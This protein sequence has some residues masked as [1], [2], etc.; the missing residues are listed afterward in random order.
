MKEQEIRQLLV[1]E[2]QGKEF[3]QCGPN[4]P[5]AIMSYLKKILGISSS[6][7]S[8]KEE[9]ATARLSYIGYNHNQTIE[10]PIVTIH[11]KKQ[12][13]DSHYNWGYS[14]CDWTIKDIEVVLCD[15]NQNLDIEEVIQNAEKYVKEHLKKV[16]TKYQV[17]K[18]AMKA[19]KKIC[20]DNQEDIYKIFDYMKSN[21]YSLNDE[22]N[23]E[24]E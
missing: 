4:S 5:Y 16:D 2:F 11:I 20:A 13:G 21:Y 24:E 14:Y 10:H 23:K 22:I 9:R 17:A 12:K 18:E 3:N 7:C 19:L 1:K 6:Q 15:N 8:I